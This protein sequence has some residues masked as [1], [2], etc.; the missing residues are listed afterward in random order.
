M[1]RWDARKKEFKKRGGNK[2]ILTRLFFLIGGL[3][4]W[5]SDSFTDFR[6][7]NPRKRQ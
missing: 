7:K 6:K 1:K 2:N 3:I 5:I 4:P